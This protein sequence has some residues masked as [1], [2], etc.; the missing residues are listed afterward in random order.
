M[1]AVVNLPPA[2]ALKLRSDTGLKAL[3]S[4]G[5]R[6]SYQARN[7]LFA[8][9][10][11]AQGM[12]YILS[13]SVAIVGEVTDTHYITHDF[14]HPGECIGEIGYFLREA[15][16]QRTATA[17][18]R[19]ATDVIFI[20]YESL[21]EVTQK[22][23]QIVHMLAGQM[24]G[25]MSQTSRRMREMA[26]LDVQSRIYQ[27]LVDLSKQPNALSHPLGKQVKITRVD[28][29]TFVGCSREVAGR[30]I[31]GLVEQGLIQTSGGRSMVILH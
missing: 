23:P 16:A 20:S 4:A 8:S 11:A 30:S 18:A 25:R 22:H 3:I 15:G 21:D 26:F 1:N 31:N 2:I 19:E 17:R 27:V 6:R 7:T 10:D 12:F 28:I 9:G 24:A 13:G 29:C 5:Q 14:I